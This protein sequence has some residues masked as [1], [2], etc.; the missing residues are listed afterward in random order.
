MMQKIKELIE[1]IKA[2]FRVRKQAKEQLVQAK[3]TEEYYKLLKSGATF[4]EFIYNDLEKMKKQS[5]NRKQRRR[6]EKQLQEKGKFSA[7]M[8][9]HYH[10]HVD[11]VLMYLDKQ[12]NPPKPGQVKIDKTKIAEARKKQE[13]TKQNG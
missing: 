1:K 6:W 3:K 9:T 11:K 12:I 10:Q 4:L 2:W 7:E 5:L 13:V 8:I